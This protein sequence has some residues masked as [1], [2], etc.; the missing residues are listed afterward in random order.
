MTFEIKRDDLCSSAVQALLAE[1]LRCMYEVSPPECVHALDLAG[2]R[3]PEIT[4]W[5]A[6]RAGQLAGC[7]ALKEIDSGHGEVKSMR[8]ASA[9]LRQGVAAAML[10]HIIAEA[11]RRQYQRLSLET[12]PMAYFEPACRLY[13]RYGFVECGP[14]AQYREDP[15]SVFM[16]LELAD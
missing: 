2:L 13:A 12:G 4:C 7:G 9:F 3:R 16:T 1:H 11:R 14:F 5:S 6:W 8:T 15:H 10:E